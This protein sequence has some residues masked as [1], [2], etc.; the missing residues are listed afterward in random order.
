MQGSAFPRCAAASD[1]PPEDI[2]KCARPQFSQQYR[3][4]GHSEFSV[5]YIADVLGYKDARA[6]RRIFQKRDRSHAPVNA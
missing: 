5:E 6:F 2:V 4:P 3:S 1:A